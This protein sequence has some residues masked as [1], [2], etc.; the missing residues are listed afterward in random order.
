MVD[1]LRLP[2][3]FFTHSAADVQWPELACIICPEDP[4][5]SASRS[6]ALMEN[7]AIADWFFYQRIH[8][9]IGVFYKQVLGASDYWVWF[10]W[11]H[12]GSPH[13][14]GLAWLQNAPNVDTLL[15]HTCIN[16]LRNVSSATEDVDMQTFLE[17]VN[18]TV[19][20][21]NPSVLPN[22]SNVAE[23]SLPKTS[24]HICNKPYSE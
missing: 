15:S 24:P 1:M 19:T 21:I 5:S 2:T 9:F 3:I 14:H 18:R 10:E 8:K 11:Q 16:T 6:K 4:D 20:T 13:V 22:G 23:A 7:P 12:R 17:Y